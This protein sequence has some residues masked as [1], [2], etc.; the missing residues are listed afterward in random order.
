MGEAPAPRELRS[1][2]LA[3]LAAQR[4]LLHVF[5]KKCGMSALARLEHLF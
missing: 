4:P 3:W 5:L 2:E 1:N